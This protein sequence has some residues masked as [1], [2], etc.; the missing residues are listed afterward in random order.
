MRWL[1][2]VLAAVVALILIDADGTSKKMDDCIQLVFQLLRQPWLQTVLA[3][4]PPRV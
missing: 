4:D 2:I 3:R 1:A